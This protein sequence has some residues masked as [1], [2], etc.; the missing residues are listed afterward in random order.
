M[1]GLSPEELRRRQKLKDKKPRVFAKLAEFG[2]RVARGES[3]AI[4]QLQYR[5]QCNFSCVH[6]SIKRFQGHLD[7]RALTPRDVAAIADQADAMGLA[8]FVITGGEPLTFAD[9]DQVVAAIDPQRFYINCDT[10]GWFLDED[11]AKH[12]A[13][14]GVDRIQLSIDSLDPAA[15]DEF[16]RCPGA[17]ARALRAV[18]AAASAGLDLFVQT[19]VTKQRLHSPEFLQFVEYFNR[20]DIGVFVTFAKPVGAWEG[21]LDVIIDDRDLATMRTLET[22]YRVFTHLTPAYGLNLGC[23]AV[24][25]MFSITEHGD[26]LPC[27]YLHV[28]LGNVLREP[29]ATIVQRGLSGHYF[30]D[31][32]DTCLIA[33]DRDFITGIVEGRIKGRPVPIPWSDAFP[34]GSNNRRS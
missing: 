23:I 20:R 24:K 6:C 34:P 16:R 29:L 11:R 8:R 21:N 7:R 4:V 3:I 1:A 17:H 14:I 10:N 33:A 28:S 19:V 22:K 31:H 15:H 26:V 18:D 2:P 9:F 32:H 30:G 25:G 13:A 12:L 5:Y 27:P